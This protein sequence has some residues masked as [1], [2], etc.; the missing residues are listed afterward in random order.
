MCACNI[1][2]SHSPCRHSHL[3]R[4]YLLKIE[5]HLWKGYVQ[6][7]GSRTGGDY[8]LIRRCLLDICSPYGFAMKIMDPILSTKSCTERSPQR[9]YVQLHRKVPFQLCWSELIISGVTMNTE[10]LINTK[11][12]KDRCVNSFLCLHIESR[13]RKEE[14][15]KMIG[16]FERRWNKYRNVFTSS[17]AQMFFFEGLA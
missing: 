10:L 13:H 5:C 4:R 14:E 16:C 17:I 11:A 15:K 8:I 2:F 3:Q 1:Q 7:N 9:F 12:T 6:I